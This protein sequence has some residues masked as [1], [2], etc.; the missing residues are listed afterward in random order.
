MHITGVLQE[1]LRAGDVVFEVLDPDQSRDHYAGE[2]IEVNGQP[3]IYRSLH[4]WTELA[5]VLG[6][7]LEVPE[8]IA[9]GRVRLRFRSLRH[10]VSWHQRGLGSGESEKYGTSSE[11]AR[12]SK[13]ETPSFLLSFLEGVAFLDLT[14]QSRILSLGVNQ[15]DELALFQQI[16]GPQALKSME[17]VGL[18]H[19]ATAIARARQRFSHPSFQFLEADIQTLSSLNL[20]RFDLILAI[21]TLHSPALKGHALFQ[22]CI[23]DHLAPKGGVLIGV[24]NSRHVDHHL[25]YGARMKNFSSPDLSVLWKEVGFY[26]RYLHQHGF[27]VRVLGKHTVLVV[28]RR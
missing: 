1:A 13:V 24:P 5:E 23:Q 7:V 18:D 25:V 17:L 15:G 19:S 2:S 16:V 12:T 27:R 9:E 11:F 21:N 22:E 28:G 20:G 10:Q 3:F 8:R 6:A 26:R 4:D 14:P